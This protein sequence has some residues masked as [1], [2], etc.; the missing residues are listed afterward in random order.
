M[1]ARAYK[2]APDLSV[3]LSAGIGDYFG[4][5]TVDKVQKTAKLIIF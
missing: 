5:V 4:C 2:T 1:Y 3:N